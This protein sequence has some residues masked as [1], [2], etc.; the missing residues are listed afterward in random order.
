MLQEKDGGDQ[1]DQSCE[2]WGI[3]TIS[4]GGEKYPTY[5][6]KEEGELDWSHLF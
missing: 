2:K 6:E 3:I 4:Q 1:L 5:N